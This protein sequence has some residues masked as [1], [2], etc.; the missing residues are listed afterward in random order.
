MKKLIDVTEEYINHTLETGRILYEFDY[1]QMIHD[2]E[3]EMA[4]WICEK[5]GGDIILLTENGSSYGVRRSDYEWRGRYWELKSVKSERSVD[6]ALRKAISQIYEKPGGVILD[7]G[8]NNVRLS[9]IEA[10]IKSRLESSCRFRIDIIIVVSGNLQ[11]VLR[12]E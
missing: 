4:S 5:L 1:N 11:K 12:Y 3:I 2:E 9:Q 10:A 7:F 6:S 8:K